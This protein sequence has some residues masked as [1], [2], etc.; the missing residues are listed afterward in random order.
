MQ[1]SLN[2]RLWLRHIVFA[3][4]ILLIPYAYFAIVEPRTQPDPWTL[5]HEIVLRYRTNRDKWQPYNMVEELERHGLFQKVGEKTTVP[6]PFTQ[7]IG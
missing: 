4:P 2:I 5:L 1:N 7:S 3:L 6:F